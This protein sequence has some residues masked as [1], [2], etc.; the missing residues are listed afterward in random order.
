MKILTLRSS[1]LHMHVS[2]FPSFSGLHQCPAYTGTSL[3]STYR[4]VDP[5]DVWAPKYLSN[6]LFKWLQHHSIFRS[7]KSMCSLTVWIPLLCL[8]STTNT[9]LNSYFKETS[10]F[11]VTLFLIVSLQL[12]FPKSNIK[13]TGLWHCSI[14]WGSWDSN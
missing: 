5:W 14:V 10:T 6:C 11:F 9:P 12:I 8:L 2:K 1:Q 13:C 4:L 3:K 7:L